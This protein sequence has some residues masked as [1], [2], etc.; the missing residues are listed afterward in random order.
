VLLATAQEPRLRDVLPDGRALLE[1]AQLRRE[2]RGLG[3]GQ[4]GERDLTWLSFSVALDLASDGRAAVLSSRISSKKELD[5]YLSRF[6]GKPPVRLGEGL[7]CGLSPDGR[8]VAA[9]AQDCTVL[10]LLPTGAGQRMRLPAGRVKYYYDVR[11]LS[12]GKR[13]LFA[14]NEERRA[15]RLFLQ[16]V[17]SGP[18]RPVTPEGVA[19]EYPIPS[20]DG[21]WVAAGADWRRA[22]YALYPL[23]GG[24]P[25]SIA[26]LEKGEEPLRFDGDGTHLFLRTDA[27]DQPSLRVARLDLR[28]GRKEVW[29]EIRPADASGIPSIGPFY[30]TPDGSNYVYSHERTLSTLYLVEGLR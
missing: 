7:G 28:T 13:L 8:W 12:D 26:G 16:D 25:R 9:V 30:L 1:L 17:A 6:D 3:A 11:W 21:K 4:A 27:R 19:A 23:D 20:P 14:G 22:P 24:E 18:P 2:V 5:T 29:K 10:D 15:R